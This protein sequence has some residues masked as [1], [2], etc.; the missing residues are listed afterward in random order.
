VDNAANE[1][2]YPQMADFTFYG[3]I[4][5]DVNIICVNNSHFDL[6]YCGTPG[7]KITPEVCGKDARVEIE[8]W[9]TNSKMGQSLRYTICAACGCEVASVESDETKV[10]L[11]INAKLNKIKK[12]D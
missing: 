4:Y 9:V 8:T 1:T 10:V 12:H 6:D 5:R 11:D 7:L 2:V 3:G